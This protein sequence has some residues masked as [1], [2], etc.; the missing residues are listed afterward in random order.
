MRLKFHPIEDPKRFVT[1]DVGFTETTVLGGQRDYVMTMP[2]QA[3]LLEGALVRVRYT[4]SEELAARIDQNA[5]RQT[6]LGQGA[7][8]VVFRPTVE[9][10]VRARVAE[11]AE[12]MGEAAALDLW[13]S[14]QDIAAELAAQLRLAHAGYLEAVRI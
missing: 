8:K 9:R 13:L 7:V 11:M 1:L 3:P 4:V 6:L 2:S 10:A 5:I 12:D 14:S